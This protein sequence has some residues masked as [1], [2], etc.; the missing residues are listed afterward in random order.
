MRY[1]IMRSTT[2]EQPHCVMPARSTGRLFNFPISDMMVCY[3]EQISSFKISMNYDYSLCILSGVIST[4][5]F[6]L[7][8]ITSLQPIRRRFFEVFYYA[9]Y[10]AIPAVVFAVLHSPQ[11]LWLVAFAL[12]SWVGDKLWR[13]TRVIQKYKIRNLK[14]LPGDVTSFEVS[15]ENTKLSGFKPGQYVFLRFP[16]VSKL[17]WHPITIASGPESSTARFLIKSFGKETWSGQVSRDPHSLY[18]HT[19]NARHLPARSRSSMFMRSLTSFTW[20]FCRNSF[21]TGSAPRERLLPPSPPLDP[22]HHCWVAPL[23]GSHL[24]LP[25]PWAPK[26]RLCCDIPSCGATLMGPMARWGWTSQNPRP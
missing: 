17:Q 3:I 15:I 12:L 22:A 16:F 25:Q 21:T 1:A 2:A 10:L 8:I 19:L 18:L 9:H 11:S 23:C 7:V 13:A 14:L 4:A 5:L 20:P 24:W 6:G 26:R